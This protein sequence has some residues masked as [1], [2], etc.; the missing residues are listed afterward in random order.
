MALASPD[1]WAAIH[2]ADY[3][4]W[5]TTGRRLASYH[6][7]T[8]TGRAKGIDYLLPEET[9]E[10]H[11]DDVADWGLQYGGWAT[12]ASPRGKISIRVEATNRSPR[13]RRRSFREGCLRGSRTTLH[14]PR[15]RRAP[16][17]ISHATGCVSRP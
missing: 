14:L 9:L 12:M 3:P 1:R 17:G 2:P 13:G 11:P 16:A 15:L 8:Q 4:V 6:S 5:L 7:R 10:V